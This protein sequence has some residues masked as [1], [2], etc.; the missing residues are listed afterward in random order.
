MLASCQCGS[1]NCSAR[2]EQTS[3]L[4]KE[5]AEFLRRLWRQ[6]PADSP[7]LFRL[8]PD[9][10]TRNQPAGECGGSS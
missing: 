3:L 7:E 2:V 5:V 4:Y 10:T 1:A 9:E 6:Q 8:G